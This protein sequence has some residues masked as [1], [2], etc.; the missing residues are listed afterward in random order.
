MLYLDNIDVSKFFSLH[1]INFVISKW[2][3]VE[4]QCDNHVDESVALLTNDIQVTNNDNNDDE[5]M[6]DGHM[7]QMVNDVY[8]YFNKNLD[9]N[10]DNGQATSID[11]MN[12]IDHYQKLIEDVRTLLYQGCTSFTKISSTMKLYNL[13]VKNGWS[14]TSLT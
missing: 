10:C 8:Q 1:C 4:H 6:V 9:V 12:D 11:E 2:Q 7:V 14:N 5:T 3:V 13:K